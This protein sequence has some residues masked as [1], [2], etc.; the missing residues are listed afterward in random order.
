MCHHYRFELQCA[1]SLLSDL[2]RLSDTSV[3]SLN[4]AGIKLFQAEVNICILITTYCKACVYFTPQCV[5]R[6]LMCMFTT[7]AFLD[8]RDGSQ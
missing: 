6:P 3:F 5:Q 8:S 2:L 4:K 1:W 7:I